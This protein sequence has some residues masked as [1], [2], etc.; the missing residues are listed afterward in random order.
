[1]DQ[2]NWLAEMVKI[3]RVSLETGMRSMDIFQQQAEKAIEFTLNSSNL[4][5]DE[6]KKA[7]HMWM[8]NIK[9]A[10]QMYADSIEEGI[11]NLENQF[12]KDKK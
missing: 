3:A 8:E 6:T 9:K 7:I 10:R 1:M 5:Q 12:N 4:S 2:G 11:K